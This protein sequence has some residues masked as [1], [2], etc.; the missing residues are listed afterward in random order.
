MVSCESF[1]QWAWWSSTFSN[2]SGWPRTLDSV[3]QETDVSI[4]LFQAIPI[5]IQLSNEGTCAAGWPWMARTALFDPQNLPIATHL[6]QLQG[7]V[8]GPHW[9]A[10]PPP[11]NSALSG[12]HVGPWW[13]DQGKFMAN[14]K[15]ISMVYLIMIHSIFYD[16]VIPRDG[17]D[18]GT[19]Q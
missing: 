11:S 19:V 14:G 2:Y 4:A 16:C 9:R 17:N 7:W 18:W 6:W 8:V 15:W 12:P 1:I 10:T 13:K 5:S 3:V